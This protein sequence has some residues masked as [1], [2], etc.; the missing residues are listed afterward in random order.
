MHLKHTTWT[1]YGFIPVAIA[2]EKFRVEGGELHLAGHPEGGGEGN[3]VLRYS[4]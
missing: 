1:R 3:R 2:A 4:C